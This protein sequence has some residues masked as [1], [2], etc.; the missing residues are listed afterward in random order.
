M[1]EPS[2]IHQR[3]TQNNVPWTWTHKQQE[4]FNC[5]KQVLCSALVLQ[6]PVPVAQFILDTKA[7]LTGIVDVLFQ[8][9]NE[10]ERLIAYASRNLSRT[11]Q[12]YCVT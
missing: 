10:Q 3:L 12:N 1:P 2:P 6:Y 11:E 5:L 8:V 4:N 7:S 9:I